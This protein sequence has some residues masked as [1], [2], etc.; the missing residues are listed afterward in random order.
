MV[1]KGISD[2]LKLQQKISGCFRTTEGVKVFCRI[3]SYLSSVRK[4]GG[5]LL[6]A[7]KSATKG[8]PIAFNI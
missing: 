8:K 7:I 6:I 1:R 5:G 2:R 4:Q 3:R